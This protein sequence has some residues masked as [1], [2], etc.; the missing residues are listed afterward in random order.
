MIF[1]LHYSV[2]Y[3]SMFFFLDK[4]CIKCRHLDTNNNDD[5]RAVT[6]DEVDLT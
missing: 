4:F 5:E 1:E 2:H 3:P 6:R